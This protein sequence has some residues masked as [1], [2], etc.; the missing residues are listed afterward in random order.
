MDVAFFRPLKGAWRQLLDTWKT[1][2]VRDK[3]AA[4][5]NKDCFP[6]FLK[7]TLDKLID[8]NV[9]NIKAGFEKTGI[10]PLN[11]N[12]VLN[13]LPPEADDTL[14]SVNSSLV[15]SEHLTTFLKESRYGTLETE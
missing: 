7:S 15:S 6:S 4:T 11:R 8:R 3:K 5:I 12:K 2:S 10:Y 1:S 13:M 9:E 14:S